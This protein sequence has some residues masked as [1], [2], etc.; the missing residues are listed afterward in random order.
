MREDARGDDDCC[1]TG[2]REGVRQMNRRRILAL[3]AVSG[4]SLSSRYALAADG[5]SGS[6]TVAKPR[7]NRRGGIVS[8][9]GVWPDLK[10]SGPSRQVRSI[11]YSRGAYSV[12][13]ADGRSAFFLESDLRF[14]I[15]SS[16]LGR[17][18]ASRSSCRPEPK[19]IAYGCF[20]PRPR[21]SAR[22][23]S[24]GSRELVLAQSDA[25]NAGSEL[26]RHFSDAGA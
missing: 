6:T 20:S 14:K 7:P 19:A 21:R 12:T 5:N 16:E 25:R 9:S 13:T 15:D 3:L 8:G 17:T 24:T 22:S 18:T 1:S 10:L 23:S 11:A 26:S 2:H 4:A